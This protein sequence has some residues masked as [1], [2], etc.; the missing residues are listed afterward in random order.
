MRMGRKRQAQMGKEVQRQRTLPKR[1]LRREI[2]PF[3]QR[4]RIG[5]K[6]FQHLM[7]FRIEFTVRLFAKQRAVHR[8]RRAQKRGNTVGHLPTDN[9]R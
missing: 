8:K 9:G 6:L 1:Q 7:P 2:G 3:E 4:L 5:Q